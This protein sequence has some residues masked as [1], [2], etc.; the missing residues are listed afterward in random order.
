MSNVEF[1]QRTNDGHIALITDRIE[2]TNLE[3]VTHAEEGDAAECSLLIKDV[4]SS[5]AIRGWRKVY[6]VHPDI[7]ASTDM[8]AGVVW[9]GYTGPREIRRDEGARIATQRWIDMNMVDLNTVLTRRLMLGD[10]AKR[11]AETDLERIAWLLGTSEASLID[12]DTYVSTTG[13]VAMDK[14]DLR[15]QTVAQIIDDCA[16]QSGKNWF[17]IN[18]K[19]TP[20]ADGDPN[21][22]GLFY[23]FDSSTVLTSVVKVSNDPADIGTANVYQPSMDAKLTIDPAQVYSGVIVD[24]SGG[25]VY[26]TRPQTATDY[27]LS[28]RDTTMSAPNIKTKAKATARGNRYLTTLAT[29]NHVI[30]ASIRVAAADLNIL[31]A[32]MRAQF[33]FTEFATEGYGDFVYMRLINRT[34]RPAGDAGLWEIAFEATRDIPAEPFTGNTGGILYRSAG[35]FDGGQ[36]YFD[37]SGDLP[38]SGL[39]ESPTT[40]L[41]E[42]IVDGSPPD[43]GR[44]FAGWKMLGDGTVDGEIYVTTVGVGLNVAYTMTLSLAVNGTIVQSEVL[45]QTVDGYMASHILLTFTGVTVATDDELIAI[46]T[47]SPAMPFFGTPYG[48]GQ[49][50]ERFVITGGSLT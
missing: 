19:Q 20:D 5:F 30:S 40:G 34:I 8:S 49:Q 9:V 47:C 3:L 26:V 48:A 17:V 4:D 37:A 24:Y 31:Q 39:P 36:V 11:P 41:I 10:D 46:L 27:A 1:Y 23:D 43:A 35:P 15:K 2:R 6:A 7:N 25:F 28:G 50:G 16:Q 45:I 21:L 38:E 14:A 33:K 32:G 29:E 12:D 18:L 13:G 22:F 44:P 42:A